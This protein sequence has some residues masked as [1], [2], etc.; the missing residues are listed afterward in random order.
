[1]LIATG[2]WALIHLRLGLVCLR[3]SARTLLSDRGDKK[4]R[5]GLCNGLHFVRSAASLRIYIFVY[6]F[7]YIIYIYKLYIYIYIDRVCVCVKY[8]IHIYREREI[9][10]GGWRLPEIHVI[11]FGTAICCVVSVRV[12][13]TLRACKILILP[14][15]HGIFALT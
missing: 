2:V 11:P 15:S 1:M 8:V 4:C 10:L 12:F 13:R 5:F 14:V 6:C 3:L 9:S 7:I